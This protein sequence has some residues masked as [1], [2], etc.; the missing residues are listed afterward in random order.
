MGKHRAKREPGTVPPRELGTVPFFG[1]QIWTWHQKQLS[2]GSV[3]NFH[4]PF[5]CCK[6]EILKNGG[7]ESNSLKG[8]KVV[9]KITIREM[10]K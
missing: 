6:D 7:T 9:L 8:K 5:G 2:G 10:R 4:F 3:S 1:G